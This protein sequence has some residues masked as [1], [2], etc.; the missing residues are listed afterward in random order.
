M[1]KRNVHFHFSSKIPNKLRVVAITL[2]PNVYF[3]NSLE[4]TPR[5]ILKHELVHVDQIESSNPIA[6][7]LS[8]GLDWIVQT[9]KSPT[10]DAYWSL[11]SEKDA[12]AR[13]M[14]GFTL[15][16]REILLYNDITDYEVKV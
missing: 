10:K 13:Q 14:E 12:R 1:R 16:D 3:A 8:Y 2:Y 11:K 9:I 7:Y 5:C 6:F 15:R 4:S